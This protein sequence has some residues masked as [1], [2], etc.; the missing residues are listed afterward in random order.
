MSELHHQ[1]FI[2]IFFAQ[3]AAWRYPNAAPGRDW[4][5][6]GKVEFSGYGL[7]YR[8]GLDLVIRDI[9]ATVAG[10]VTG[11]TKNHRTRI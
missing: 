5:D 8:E 7:R 2:Y 11:W 4:P 10:N 9:T 1:S 6:S 3:E